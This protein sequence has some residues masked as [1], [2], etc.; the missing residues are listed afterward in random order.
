MSELIVLF[1]EGV[2]K[3]I[4]YG[5]IELM[6]RDDFYAALDLFC[7]RY[8]FIMFGFIKVGFLGILLIS[9]NYIESFFF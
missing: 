2:G 5:K 1:L 9:F 4:F 7:L 3:F 6:L 8:I